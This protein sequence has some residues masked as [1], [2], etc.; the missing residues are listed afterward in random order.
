MTSMATRARPCARAASQVAIVLPAGF[1]EAAGAALFGERQA[2]HSAAVRP[3]AA[4]RAGDGEGHADAAGDAGVSAEMFGG[5]LG[6]KVTERS[7]QQLDDSKAQDDS[8]AARHA[9][10]RAASTR[11][12]AR[13]RYGR[14]PGARP[15]DAVHDARRGPDE[16]PVAEGYNAYAHAFCRH[17]RAVHPVHGHDMGI[18]M[19]LARRSGV[20][21]R[22]LAAPVTLTQV[23]LARAVSAAIIAT[24]LLCAIFAWQCWRSACTSPACR[25][26][27]AWRCA[28]ARSRPASAC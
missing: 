16:R 8:R 19:L 28:S 3:V 14:C 7:L 13:R 6:R 1:R 25:A 2:G 21:N 12:A 5:A 17:G 18:G 9:R 23:L 26:S 15:D 11:P 22:L 10:Q 27:S 20:W 4:G 24:C